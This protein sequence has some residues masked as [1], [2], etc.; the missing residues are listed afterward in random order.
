MGQLVLSVVDVAFMG[1][2][3][4][5]LWFVMRKSRQRTKRIAEQLAEPVTP[6]DDCV[7]VG[8][9]RRPALVA[10]VV[11]AVMAFSA[12]FWGVQRNAAA[13]LLVLF[14]VGAGFI[15]FGR[16]A[17]R[18]GPVLAL[19][20]RGLTIESRR[21]IPWASVEKAWLDETRGLYGVSRYS[22]TFETIEPGDGPPQTEKLTVP[23]EMLRMPWNEI[24]IAIQDRLGRHVPVIKH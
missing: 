13:D 1:G 19:D 12:L 4:A 24:V 22:L 14:V 6:A 23:L 5:S 11:F 9:D 10:G 18:R 21:F 17:L 15:V 20:G 7:F 3:L 2:L 8:R 16:Y